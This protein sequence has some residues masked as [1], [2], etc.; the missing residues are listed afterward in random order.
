[1][2]GTVVTL[3][4]TLLA[5]VPAPW[6]PAVDEQGRLFGRLD[7]ITDAWRQHVGL[8]RQVSLSYGGWIGPNLHVSA[9]AKTAGLV[10]LPVHL[11]VARSDLALR[12]LLKIDRGGLARVALVQEGSSRE[13]LRLAGPDDQLLTWGWRVPL[14]P[15]KRDF[16]L[17]FEL[18]GARLVDV[19]LTSEEYQWAQLGT[20]AGRPV[21]RAVFSANHEPTDDQQMKVWH[22]RMNLAWSR[23]YYEIGRDWKG[24]RQVDWAA[25]R[26]RLEHHRQ[27]RTPLV[28]LQMSSLGHDTEG[29]APEDWQAFYADQRWVVG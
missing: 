20:P 15:V 18:R 17:R 11:D 5:A 16:T 4:L 8:S 9:S 14:G 25:V 2:P 22:E 13:L 28:L 29:R 7:F 12:P 21:N 6:Q 24:L 19:A 1:M 23:P 26:K 10:V 3:T 27:V